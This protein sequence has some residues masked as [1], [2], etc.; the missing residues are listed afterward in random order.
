MPVA[1]AAITEPMSLRTAAIV[2]ARD[3]L[4]ATRHSELPDPG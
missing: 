4:H 2:E 3:P 1:A